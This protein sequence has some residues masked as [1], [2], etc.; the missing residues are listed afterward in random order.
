MQG[1]SLKEVIKADTPVRKYALF[2]IHGGQIYITDGRYVFMK[3]YIDDN[4]PLYNYTQIA[5]HMKSLF[6]IR[7][8][9][10]MQ[11]HK[12][13]S[14]TKGTP[15][16]KTE[17]R[18]GPDIWIFVPEK[19]GDRLYDLYNDPKQENPIQNKEIEKEMIKNMIRLMIEN[20]CPEEQFVRLGFKKEYLKMKKP[21]TK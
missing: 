10:T 8:L 17:A 5:T 15:V 1:Y 2:G 4:K 13:F 12:G 18:N 11:I 7:E 3:D 14:F 21:K 16:M 20:D 9:K 6:S 19:F